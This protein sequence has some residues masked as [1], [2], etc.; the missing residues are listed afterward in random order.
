MELLVI[1]GF[2]GSGKTTLLIS[3]AR[4]IHK[5]RPGVKIAVVENEAGK[6][7]VDGGLIRSGG[8]PVREIYSGCVCCTLKGELTQAI[9]E[10]HAAEAPD[11]VII[12]PSGV[13]VPDALRDI[14]DG[15]DD[16]ASRFVFAVCIDALRHQIINIMRTPYVERGIQAADILALNKTDTADSQT[17]SVIEAEVKKLR[18]GLEIHQ[19]SGLRGDGMEP[20]VKRLLELKPGARSPALPGGTQAAQDGGGPVVFSREWETLSAGSD[21]GAAL[22]GLLD[23]IASA[24]EKKGKPVIGHIKALASAVSGECLSASVTA[25][26]QTPSLRG[27]FKEP[28]KKIRVALNVIVMDFDYLSLSTVCAPVIRERLNRIQ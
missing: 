24:L 21:I 3:A 28:P 25:Y 12:E 26:G 17:V 7:G 10:L 22:G 5:L 9:R 4:H 20:F 2:L 18:P 15:L 19:V 1:S 11:I 6:N 13:A 8:L 14:F 23:G 27:G 16:I